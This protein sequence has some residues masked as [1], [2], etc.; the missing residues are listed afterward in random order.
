[1]E[2]RI[3]ECRSSVRVILSLDSSYMRAHRTVLLS[4]NFEVASG[5]HLS[6]LFEVDNFSLGF[7]DE[8]VGGIHVQKHSPPGNTL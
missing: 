2:E 8:V 5:V 3:N 6:S 4:E 7:G 1:M